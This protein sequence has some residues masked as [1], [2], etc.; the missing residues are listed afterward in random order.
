MRFLI[1]LVIF[2]ALLGQLPA[3]AQVDSA[4]WPFPYPF[5]VSCSLTGTYNANVEGISFPSETPFDS[6][7]TY[8]SSTVPEYGFPSNYFT[9]NNVTMTDSLGWHL[10]NQ[11]A[12]A[13]IEFDSVSH[14]ILQLELN[15]NLDIAQPTE[16]L[17][18]V[19]HFLHYNDS[20]ISCSDNDLWRHVS[21]AGYAFG[22]INAFE[23]ETIT[24]SG[25]D[26]FGFYGVQLIPGFSIP[27]TIDFGFQSVGSNFDSSIVLINRSDTVLTI[28]SFALQDSDSGFSFID[29]TAHFIAA[30]DSAKITVRFTPNETK[31]YAGNVHIITD[32]PYA[33]PYNILLL[34]S[35]ETSG[36]TQGS[37]VDSNFTASLVTQERKLLLQLSSSY[38][39][40]RI[41]VFDIL[42]HKCAAMNQS[43]NAGENFLSL[44]DLI[45]TPGEY[46]VRIQSGNEVRSLKFVNLQ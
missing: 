3:R 2:I 6:S 15:F 14:T 21:S 17:H 30:Q 40:A 35:T 18:Y 26:G 32:E 38:S 31:M 4:Q 33:L 5:W 44:N 41:D 9:W 36:V 46:I 24:F 28:Y 29:T 20:T 1:F 10:A 42:G 23:N 11:A 25:L 12:T 45:G 8:H 16:S 7:W 13:T 27:S 34:G 39:S 22:D 43:L 19:L 37:S